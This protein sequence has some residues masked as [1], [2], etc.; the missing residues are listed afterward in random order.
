MSRKREAKNGIEAR[1]WSLHCKGYAPSRIDK[2]L[3]LDKGEA[4]SIVVRCWHMDWS[5]GT[6]VY[7]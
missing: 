6:R 4:R 2:E 1:V 5:L 7:F 3:G